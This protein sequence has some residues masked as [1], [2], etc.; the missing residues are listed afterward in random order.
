M[1]IMPNDY[2][3]KPSY[4]TPEDLFENAQPCCVEARLYKELEEEDRKQLI[5]PD[6]ARRMR[7]WQ[8]LTNKV[9]G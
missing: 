5:N 9:V 6:R 8:E 3:P 1:F 2:F 7:D 4:T